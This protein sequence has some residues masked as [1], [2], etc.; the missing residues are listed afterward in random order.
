MNSTHQPF[1]SKLATISDSPKLSPQNSLEMVGS[2]N[3]G[4]FKLPAP[5]R[6]RKNE[7]GI[8][9]DEHEREQIRLYKIEVRSKA[10]EVELAGHRPGCQSSDTMMMK[11]RPIFQEWVLKSSDIQSCPIDKLVSDIKSTNIKA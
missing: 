7:L 9:L 4:M 8:A 6:F 5:R 1:S 3:V 2:V 10:L 11:W